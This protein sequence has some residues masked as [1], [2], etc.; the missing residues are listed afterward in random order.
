MRSAPPI[1]PGPVTEALQAVDDFFMGKS[2]VH[3]SAEVLSARLRQ[4]NI[5]FALAGA[6]AVNA[7]GFRRMTENVNIL[8]TAEG[9]QR[10]KERWLGKG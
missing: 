6:L 5:D 2:K 3:R 9:L 1:P 10:F 4:E 7:H 8:I